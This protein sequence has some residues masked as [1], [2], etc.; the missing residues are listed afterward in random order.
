[1]SFTIDNKKL[2][3]ILAEVEAEIVPVLKNERARLLKK[4]AEESGGE[5]SPPA[6]ESS[7]AGCDGGAEASAGG[8]PAEGSGPPMGGPEASAPAEGSAPPPGAE[9]SAGAPPEASGGLPADPA[10]LQQMVAQLPPEQQEALYLAVK[11]VLFARQGAGPEASAGGPPGAP[12]AGPP[13]G[14]PPGAPPMGAG[15]EAS[16]G[17]PPPPGPEASG[18]LPPPALKSEFKASPGNGGKVAKSERETKLEAQ[19]KA[20][21][22]KMKTLE[23]GFTLALERLTGQPMRKAVTGVGHIAKSETAPAEKTLTKSEIDSALRKH[24]RNEKTTRE[25]RARIN[26]FYDTGS[27]NVDLIKDLLA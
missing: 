27:V 16:A 20:M 23:K 21:D 19:V 5:E 8:P 24:V 1:M 11:Q 15:P 4:A 3:D 26:K 22:E 10:A 14:G 2:K 7:D 13:M 25:T 12:P 17:G 9:A 18:G 6:E